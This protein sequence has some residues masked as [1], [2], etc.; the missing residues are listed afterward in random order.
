MKVMDY[1][2]VVELREKWLQ[3]ERTL[4]DISRGTIE[5]NK[6]FEERYQR[7]NVFLKC[8]SLVIDISIPI[9]NVTK[10]EIDEIGEILKKLHKNSSATTVMDA[11]HFIYFEKFPTGDY[12]EERTRL[13]GINFMYIEEI[14]KIL[15]RLDDK[16]RKELTKALYDGLGNY[17]GM[18]I[19]KE[20]CKD[21]EK[22]VTITGLKGNDVKGRGTR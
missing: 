2:S 11:M 1:K 8:G 16:T 22:G 10:Q 3:E 19:R 17:I 6:A 14:K 15:G 9:Y 5:K 20:I 12:A 7:E 13:V 21:K 4:G 18:S